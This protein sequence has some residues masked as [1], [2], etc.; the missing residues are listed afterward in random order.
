ML[1]IRCFIANLLIFFLTLVHSSILAQEILSGAD[2]PELYIP[3]IQGKNIAMVC[4]H[5]SMVGNTHIVDYLLSRN[6]KVKLIFA[7]EHGFRGDIDAGTKI[8]SGIDPKTG[9]PIK[10]LYGASKKP[11]K[12]DLK[13]LDF[14][15]FDIQDVG[16]RF[17]TYI[18]TLEYMLQAA[19]EAEIPML[20]LDRPNPNG[21][22]IDGPV[23][24]PAFKS[25][26]GMQ[27]IPVVYGMTIGE[28]AKMLVGENR[29]SAS[30]KP[31]LHVIPCLGYD[32]SISGFELPVPPSPNLRSAQAVALYP[33]LCFFE[34]TNVSVGRGTDR[35]FE[36][37][38]SPYMDPKKNSFSFIPEPMQG[39][40]SPPFMNKKCYGKNLSKA[41]VLIGLELNYLIQSF[42]SMKNAK[43]SFFLKNLFFDK[44]AGTDKLRKQILSRLSDKKIRDSW[45]PAIN[46]F[47]KIRKKYLL[48]Q[49]FM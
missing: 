47:K 24:E 48:Y 25:F 22:Y 39:A 37:Y 46:E 14:I 4:N 40:M 44:L 17:Y 35:P 30:K 32:H 43:D 23:L 3:I 18:S 5:S 41:P 1:K 19:A 27:P 34:G 49:D 10:S 12:E 42:Q 7:P 2:R 15:L 31:E 38:G 36:L 28:Y 8:K 33:S 20:L 45:K 26:V 11:N 6:M 21:H 29:I 16:C 9:V 13:D